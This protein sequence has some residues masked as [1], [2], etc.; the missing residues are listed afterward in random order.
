V[1]PL[2]KAV[3]LFAPAVIKGS[4]VLLYKGPDVE[5]EI[6]EAWAEAKKRRIAMRVVERYALP[7]GM[8]ERTVVELSR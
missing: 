7:D 5:A 1:A 2:E 8:G 6:G 3:P 4:K